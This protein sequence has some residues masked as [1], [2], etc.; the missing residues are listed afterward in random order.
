[1]DLD[2]EQMDTTLLPSS[3]TGTPVQCALPQRADSS[4]E[5][6]YYGDDEDELDDEERQRLADEL[7]EELRAQA[8]QD[9]TEE[10]LDYNWDEWKVAYDLAARANEDDMEDVEA[11]HYRRQY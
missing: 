1:M 7:D 3:M 8:D 6:S 2:E 4:D 10:D 11:R 5:E 9:Y